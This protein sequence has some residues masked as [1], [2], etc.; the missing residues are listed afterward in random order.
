MAYYDAEGI[1]P[2]HFLRD[3]LHSGKNHSM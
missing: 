3:L 2:G 1:A